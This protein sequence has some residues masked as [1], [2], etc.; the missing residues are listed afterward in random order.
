M[1]VYPSIGVFKFILAENGETLSR[2]T[3]SSTLSDPILLLNCTV[4]VLW[5]ISYKKH[6]MSSSVIHGSVEMKTVILEDI[7]MKYDFSGSWKKLSSSISASIGSNNYITSNTVTS[8]TERRSA[9]IFI[10]MLP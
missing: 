3:L 6:E 4:Q 7:N 1:S 8:I 5:F 2:I 9:E 10:S